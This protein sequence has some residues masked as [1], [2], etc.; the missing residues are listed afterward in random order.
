MVPSCHAIADRAQTSSHGKFE[1]LVCEISEKVDSGAS[2]ELSEYERRHPEFAERL[3]RIWPTLLAMADLGHLNRSESEAGAEQAPNVGTLGDFQIIREVGRGGM[4]VVYEATQI[5]L[6]RRV[7]LKVLPFASVMDRRQ[8]QRFKNEAMAAAA[9]DHPNVVSVY[10]TGCERS[11]HFYAMHYVEG[12]TLAEVIAQLRAT[13]DH[14]RS[15]G[16]A[17]SAVEQTVAFRPGGGPVER[18]APSAYPSGETNKELQAGISTEGSIR[19][20]DY[21]RSV[22]KIGK[23]AAEALDHAHGVGIVHR[24]VKPSN[25]IL[26]DSSRCWITDFGLAMAES[27]PSLTMTGDLLG[28]LRYMSPEQSLA[29]RV[30]VDH[31]T[32]IYSLGVTLYEL[33]TLQPAHAGDDR[34]EMLRRLAFEEPLAPRKLNP[35]IPQDLETIVLKAISK[36]ASDRYAAAGDFAADLGNYLEGRPIHAR[37]PTWAQRAAKWSL[38]HK[39]LVAAVAALVLLTTLGLA[40][41]NVLIAEQ[42]N[43]AV[44]A[45][46]R[47]QE[48]REAAQ[49][50][51][52]RAERNLYIAEMSRSAYDLANGSVRRLNETLERYGPRRGER[53]LRQWEWYYFR[54]LLQDNSIGSSQAANNSSFC[55][56]CWTENPLRFYRIA[57]NYVSVWDPAT[58][59]ET[60]RIAQQTGFGVACDVHKASGRLATGTVDGAIKIWDLSTGDLIATLQDE[61]E[62]PEVRWV[63][64]S[65]DGRRLASYDRA[66]KL[67][68][69]EVGSPQLLAQTRLQ[70]SFDPQYDVPHWSPS[71]QQI[72]VLLSSW[73]HVVVLGADGTT[74]TL[75]PDSGS[76][77]SVAWNAGG[78][79]LITVTESQI[80]WWDAETWDLKGKCDRPSATFSQHTA[81]S[82]D[83]EFLAAAQDSSIEIV[84]IADGRNVKQLS[85]HSGSVTRVAWSPDG[86]WL[87]SGSRDHTIRLWNVADNYRSR[88]L[89]GVVAPPN[90]M[91]FSPDSSYLTS[92]CDHLADGLQ[93]WSV[94]DDSQAPNELVL[95]DLAWATPSPH[96]DLVVG[97]DQEGDLGI[98]N[99]DDGARLRR[100]SAGFRAAADIRHSLEVLTFAWSTDQ[101]KIA[102]LEVVRTRDKRVKYWDLQTDQIES[103]PVPPQATTDDWTGLCIAWSPREHKI[104]YTSGTHLV[105]IDAATKETSLVTRADLSIDPRMAWSSTNRIAIAGNRRNVGGWVH[106]RDASDGRLL[107]VFPPMSRGGNKPSHV[108]WSPDGRKLAVG[109]YN[110]SIQ[111]IDAEHGRVEQLLRGHEA[112]V[113]TI[114]WTPNGSRM[115]TMGDNQVVRLWDVETGVELMVIETGTASSSLAHLGWDPAG[116]RLR[117]VMGYGR[118][119]TWDAT[120]GYD[121]GDEA[122]STSATANP[123]S[124]SVGETWATPDGS[125]SHPVDE[126]DELI[127][128]AFHDQQRAWTSIDSG[129]IETARSW[130]KKEKETLET[131]DKRFSEARAVRWVT[132]HLWI[133]LGI[134]QYRAREFEA[135]ADTLGDFIFHPAA[136]RDESRRA[137]W[138]YC[139]A[140][141]KIGKQDQA[142]EIYDE[143]VTLAPHFSERTGPEPIHWDKSLL[144]E[145]TQVML[146]HSEN[147]TAGQLLDA[148][149]T[150]YF[151]FLMTNRKWKSGD[152]PEW[153]KQAVKQEFRRAE[154]PTLVGRRFQ[155]DGYGIAPELVYDGEP[156]ITI[157]VIY[158]CDE[159]SPSPPQNLLAWTQGGN[160]SLCTVPAT[161]SEIGPEKWA[162]WLG[163]LSSEDRYLTV[164]AKAQIPIGRRQHIVGVWDGD[165]ARL[166]VDGKL[167]AKSRIDRERVQG[168]ITDLPLMLAADPSPKWTAHELFY[169]SIEAARISRVMLYDDEFSPPDLLEPVDGCVGLYDLRYDDGEFAYDRSGAGNHMIL[170][171]AKRVAPDR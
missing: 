82:P 112:A 104:G 162:F 28:T 63:R 76:F 41:S 30:V 125:D 109:Y 113:Q 103:I 52:A 138:H 46:E 148:A 95:G 16:T 73:Q 10:A 43:E 29:Q 99:A 167:Q 165:E 56:P 139:M 34:Q 6:G 62:E 149:S 133:E 59:T 14:N 158:T 50:E 105:T 151:E 114:A 123:D 159:Y 87:A 100:R 60:R 156:P 5:S 15:C 107:R 9:L 61:E 154:T 67:A 75:E 132:V 37:R 54:S 49:Q 157:E 66:Y 8:L 57:G 137:L 141:T 38:R 160:L 168:R 39:P 170:R 69:W 26:D 153:L 85:G 74:H 51:Q 4:G 111:L 150:V 13:A 140:L 19:T 71:G 36:N 35:T 90:S 96:G 11:V 86:Q 77:D 166:Y 18:T 91:S 48:Q 121:V 164:S 119:R 81:C 117:L 42:R 124:T 17:E 65:A 144:A 88:S 94:K 58:R 145:A 126:L 3:R 131:L 98:W 97:I 130:L 1:S 146:E 115:A 118:V 7:A 32:D 152:P 169:G 135:S 40:V 127:V 143:L 116:K 44:A 45:G 2:I 80:Q 21:F 155:G 24:D 12:Y 129:D 78:T 134:Q 142:R 20:R 68:I 110:G 171:N 93:V 147:Q 72:A 79:S 128:S 89:R 23:Q 106:L 25:L 22:A 33:L 27:S 163:D 31:R 70:S 108:K 55:R 47:E 122:A 101:Q 53:D 102:W 161:D 120:P 83:G 92:W 84:R 64:W 136:Y